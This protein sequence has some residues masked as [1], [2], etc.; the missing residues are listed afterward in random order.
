MGYLTKNVIVVDCKSV[1]CDH[2]SEYLDGPCWSKS[3]DSG[4]DDLFVVVETERGFVHVYNSRD[5]GVERLAVS[6][7]EGESVYLG[8]ECCEIL[9]NTE[10]V[11]LYFSGPY[12]MSFQ[13]S[14][15]RDDSICR[16]FPVVRTPLEF[17]LL[18]SLM[19]KIEQFRGES[20]FGRESITDHLNRVRENVVEYIR[21]TIPEV[22]IDAQH[23]LSEIIAHRSFVLGPL[24]PILLDEMTEEVYLDRPGSEF[25]FDHQVFGRCHTSLRS[26]SEDV[27]KIVTL[28]R[29]HSNLHLDS[30]NPSLK[31]DLTLLDASLRVSAAVAP[32]SPDGLH[33][34]IRRA[35]R[36]PFS[37]KDLVENGTLSIEAAAV[38]MFAVANRFNITITGEPGSGKT[39]LLNALDMV[40]PKK[41]RKLYIEDVIE[42]REIS[43]SHQVRF[44][45]DPVDEKLYKSSKSQEIVKCLHRSPDYVILGE[46]QT[47]E[48]TKALFQALAA[49]LRVMQTC[50]SS[51]AS[52]LISRWNVSHGIENV[53]IGL[54]DLIVTLRRPKPAQSKRIVGE[55]VEVC[56]E[57]QDGIMTFG[58][59]N[60]VYS[61]RDG[62]R[63]GW[64][65]KGS[66]LTRAREAGEESHEAALYSLVQV[67]ENPQQDWESSAICDLLWNDEHPMSFVWRDKV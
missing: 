61:E 43:D 65:D 48:H 12:L 45:V 8:T 66:F 6:T 34:E 4:S 30:S 13:K 23:R 25:Y 1:D 36:R 52:A 10:I 21:N 20:G 28:L 40:V 67:L 63:H 64:A 24:V 27:S 50:H 26:E 15:S 7:E 57:E 42:S 5:E 3:V 54:M 62:L 58:G 32:L 17:T 51:S 44:K 59:L 41:W 22:S 19:N 60:C 18:Y 31:T 33:L 46:I 11:G 35:R 9:K 53:S 29:A 2:C 47:K 38:L 56:R 55:M 37:L 39:T 49:G 14:S 16:C